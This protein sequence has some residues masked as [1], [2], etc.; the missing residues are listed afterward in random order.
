MP[1]WGTRER[2]W[3]LAKQNL[4]QGR[5][6]LI[7]AQ[8]PQGLGPAGPGSSW[9]GSQ[10]APSKA[11]ARAWRSRARPRTG[12]SGRDSGKSSCS[13]SPPP[14]TSRG[15]GPRLDGVETR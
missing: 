8:V 9:S 6:G 2:E 10:Q 15:P 14:S 12:L 5:R 1:V 13:L 3:T 7:E 11:A 4:D